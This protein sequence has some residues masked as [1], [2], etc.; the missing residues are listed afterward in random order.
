MSLS[1]TV[2]LLT[3]GTAVLSVRGEV[4]HGDAEEL[5]GAVRSILANRRPGVIRL[6]L[7]LVTF[8]DSGAVGALVSAHRIAAAEGTRLVVTTAS[9]FV[10]RQ[11]T[12]AGVADLLG[13]PRYAQPES[14]SHV[15]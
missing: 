4:D 14:G 11:L 7:G 5:R 8:M 15:R 1:V 13:V 10:A 12:I 2:A 6:D 9:P 3:D